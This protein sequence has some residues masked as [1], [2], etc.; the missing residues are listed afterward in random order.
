MEDKKFNA[1]ISLLDDDDHIVKNAVCTELSNTK[2]TKQLEK[3]LASETLCPDIQSRIHDILKAG[4]TNHFIEIVNQENSTLLDSWIAFSM[5]LDPFGNEQ[6]MRDGVAL[7]QDP[8]RYEMLRHKMDDAQV[9]NQ[10]NKVFYLV[11]GFNGNYLFPDSPSNS[12][13]NHVLESKL[14]NCHSMVMLYHIICDGLGI[15]KLKMVEFAGY[16]AL[17]YKYGHEHYYIDAYNK[18][19]FFTPKGVISFLRKV[20]ANEDIQVWPELSNKNVISR[21]C[22]LSLMVYERDGKSELV[23]QLKQMMNGINA[24]RV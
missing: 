22:E 5:A 4:R 3:Y 15:N 10:L 6:S 20:G 8:I 23:E 19:L 17:Q 1:L 12:L 13:L 11:R 2:Y 14:G 16:C 9:F 21:L 7:I 24:V 18:G